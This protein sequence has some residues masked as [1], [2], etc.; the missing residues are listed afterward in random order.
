MPSL[1]T[2][3]VTYNRK[4]LL[5]ENLKAQIG[6]TL[7][8]DHIL[9]I[10]N[11]SS[12]GTFDYLN[13]S[14]YL[15]LPNVVYYN[16]GENIGGAKA[17]ISE[18]LDSEIAAFEKQLDALYANDAMSVDADIQVMH[19]LLEREG[20]LESDELHDLIQKAQSAQ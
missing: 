6:Q 12:D 3:V 14:G 1:C 20:L 19:K 2:I 15:T 18:M 9:I 16:T 8:P 11:N 13:N 10:D 17:R 4:E 7:F 5:V